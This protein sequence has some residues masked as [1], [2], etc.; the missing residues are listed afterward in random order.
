MLHSFT[1]TDVK[2]L[3]AATEERILHVVATEHYGLDQAD[4]PR[5]AAEQA[6]GYSLHDFVVDYLR[7]LVRSPADFQVMKDTIAAVIIQTTADDLVALA[8]AK[9]VD[10]AELDDLVHDA[11]GEEAAAINND[12]LNSQIAYL[13]GALGVAEVKKHLDKMGTADADPAHPEE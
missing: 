7:Y 2:Q 11:K 6:P 5:A 10:A 4:Y 3:L 9:G 13:I 1:P 8:E 12:G